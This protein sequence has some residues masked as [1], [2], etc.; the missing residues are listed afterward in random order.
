MQNKF[1]SSHVNAAYAR[2]IQTLADQETPAFSMFPTADQ[3]ENAESFLKDIAHAVDELFYA[4][5][6]DASSNAQTVISCK[7]RIALVSDALD[8]SDLLADLR[9]EA[10]ERRED[11]R[12]VA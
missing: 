12:E 9:N 4:V 5:A 6:V 7:D 2:L 8:N 10:E 11:E 3:F 1:A